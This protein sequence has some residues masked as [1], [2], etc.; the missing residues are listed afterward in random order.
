[1]GHVILGSL[2]SVGSGAIILPRLK[3]GDGAV[4]GAGAVVTKDVPEG[5]TVMGVPATIRKA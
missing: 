1:L 2:V 4:I 3:I 5:V